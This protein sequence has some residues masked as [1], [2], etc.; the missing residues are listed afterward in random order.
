MKERFMT[1]MEMYDEVQV[2][3]YTPQPPSL[4]DLVVEQTE[5]LNVVPIVKKPVKKKRAKKP[6]AVAKPDTRRF[7]S[8]PICHDKNCPCSYWT[9]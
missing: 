1:L 5:Q 9:D 4:L 7:V 8:C 6:K 3:T 2:I